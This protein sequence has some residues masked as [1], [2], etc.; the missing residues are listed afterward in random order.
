[1][2]GR[3]RACSVNCRPTDRE[4]RERRAALR[5]PGAAVYRPSRPGVR[6]PPP[7]ACGGALLGITLRLFGTPTASLG[8]ADLGLALRSTKC[9]ALLVYLA[10]EPG[11]HSRDE[12]AALLWSDDPEEAARASLRQ[13]I[14]R[15]RDA[16]GEA[17]V[18]SRDTV[19]LAAPVACDVLEFRQ[20]LRRDSAEAAGHD[21]GAFLNGFSMH[22]AAGFEE[23]ADRIGSELRRQ[24][25]EALR[26]QARRA[27]AESRW[28]EA[29]RW[30]DAWLGGDPLSDEAT[31]IAARAAYLAGDRSAALERLASYRDRLARELKT[32]PSEALLD[33]ERRIQTEARQRPRRASRQGGGSPVSFEASLIGRDREWRTLMDVW[34][35]VSG[36]AGRVVLVEGEAGIGKTRLAEEFLRWATLEGATTL[37]GR[38]YDRQTGI[39]YGPIAEVLRGALDAPGVSATSPEWLTEVSR[40]LPEIR[41]HFPS[42]PVPGTPTSATGQW[43]LFEGMA[44]IVLAVAEERPT[45]VLVD[46]L[47][48]C[49]RDTC[50]LLRYLMRRIEGA[51]VAVVLCLAIGEL[52]RDAPAARLW[53]AQR[54]QASTTVVALPP[55]SADEVWR[56]IRELGKITAP[57]GAKRL[58]DRIHQVTDGNPFH[59][60]ELL[61][62]LFA[63]DLLR[64]DADGGEWVVAPTAE[65]A[66]ALGASMPVTIRDAVD[67]RVAQL[68][69][70]L[71]DLLA[72]VAVMGAGCRADLLSH[73]HSISRLRAAALADGLVERRLLV[74]ENGVYRCAHPVIDEVVRA[75]LTASRRR[76]V[77]RAIALSLMIVTPPQELVG[78]AGDIAHHAERAGEMELAHQHALQAS[79]A[80]VR[81]YAFDE[82]LSW[83]DLA[84]STATLQG[85]SELA[86]LRT[87][88]VL[89]LAGWSEPPPV[90]RRLGTP[91]RG[92]DFSDLDLRP[93]GP[94]GN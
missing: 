14:K 92:L 64:V 26:A 74:E 50:A 71:R 43:R 54:V 3:Q 31:L 89:K 51:P 17:L 67:A 69:H 4:L 79:E 35:A 70:E 22:R 88:E 33:L 86:N 29:A 5:R 90:Q 53:R 36:G 44:Q 45:V 13:A 63:Q 57:S 23:W 34:A 80:A 41:Q 49:D 38:G 1:L 62:S 48:G 27:M 94:S 8:D 25:E 65:I 84:A 91:A 87:A 6:F 73:V 66:K 15:L 77:H 78:A 42:L 21:V 82:A 20:A 32:R 2:Q 75:G 59:V 72:T 28:R 93:L 68:P 61:K 39:P 10:L 56:L 55:L 52:E 19:E 37:R 16:L 81:R 47:Q 11:R 46:D 85:E 30:A 60:V 83:L 40:L 24:Q 76:E 7:S 58:A 9:L 12:L 18:V